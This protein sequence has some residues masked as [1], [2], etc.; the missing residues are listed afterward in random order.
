LPIDNPGLREL[1]AMFAAALA[2][3]PQE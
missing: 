1:A 3:G 2:T